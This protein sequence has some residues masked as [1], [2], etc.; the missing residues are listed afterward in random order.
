MITYILDP[1]TS[2]DLRASK[3]TMIWVGSKGVVPSG[4]YKVTTMGGLQYFPDIIDEAF[5]LAIQAFARF[6]DGIQKAT[7]PFSETAKRMNNAR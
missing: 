6:A 4:W 1:Q 2:Q 7:E 5:K 3:R